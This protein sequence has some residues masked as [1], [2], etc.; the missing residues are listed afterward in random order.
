MGWINMCYE[1]F[2]KLVDKNFSGVIY[3]SNDD[4]SYSKAYGYADKSNLIPNEITT[5]FPIASG[6]KGFVAVSILQLIEKG[7]LSFHTTI[8]Q[9]LDFDLHEIDKNITIDQLLNH[10]SGIPDYF[11]EDVMD[12]YDEL[13]VDYP[14]YKI[15]SSYDILPLFIEKPMQYPKGS[16]FKY[17]NSGYVMLGIII[18]KVTGEKFDDYI[19]ENIFK[20][21]NMND[22][23][24]FELD[25]LPAKCAN[26]YIYDEERGDFKTNIYSV[27]VKGTGAGGAFTTGR[28]MIKFWNCLLTYKLISKELT[29][30]MVSPQAQDDKEMYGY[31]V[32]LHRKDNGNYIYQLVGGDPGVSFNS[33]VDLESN[34]RVAIISNEENNVWKYGKSISEMFK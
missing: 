28:D 15:R 23:G 17:N 29:Q 3:I 33:F 6:S 21:C 5:R 30:T 24:Y 34:L 2:E 11:D 22:T 25:R 32:W 1:E 9:I 19:K 18:E 26:A 31:G 20:P 10:T 4:E 27:D 16:R 12:E 7:L 14:M 8:G 13:W